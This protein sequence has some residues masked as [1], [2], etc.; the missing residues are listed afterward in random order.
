MQIHLLKTQ[1]KFQVS[2]WKTLD[3]TKKKP[4]ELPYIYKMQVD[5][6]WEKIHLP[7]IH[8]RI[9]IFQKFFFRF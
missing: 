4:F 2:I 3:I 6:K 9:G 8:L 1:P 7:L 5:Y